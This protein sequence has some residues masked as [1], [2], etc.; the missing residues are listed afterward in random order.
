MSTNY[1]EAL[2]YWIKQ[3]QQ[4]A[5]REMDAALRPYELGRSQWYI[6]FCLVEEGVMQQRSLQQRLGIESSTLTSLIAA[7]VRSGWIVQVPDTSD[8]RNKKIQ[9]TS[10]GKQQWQ[11]IPDPILQVRAKALQGIP[12]QDI[13][14]AKAVLKQA[15]KNLENNQEGI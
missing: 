3:Y 2:G 5:N 1:T 6:L 4:H 8:R 12:E 10:W 14:R 11:T 15:I 13:E 9:L 7:L